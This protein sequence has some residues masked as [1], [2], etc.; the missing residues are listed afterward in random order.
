[1]SQGGRSIA[2][3]LFEYEVFTRD[4]HRPGDSARAWQ[5][6][7]NVSK[8]VSLQ[9]R[10]VQQREGFST[11]A[12][13]FSVDVSP[14]RRNRRPDQVARRR[15]RARRAPVLAVERDGPGLVRVRRRRIRVGLQ[16]SGSRPH[17]R[18][19]HSAGIEELRPAD[20]Q[21]GRRERPRVSCRCDQRER[22]SIRPLIRRDGRRRHVVSHDADREGSPEPA[23]VI[24]RRAA[25]FVARA[26]G[27]VVQVRAAVGECRLQV[28]LRPPVFTAIRCS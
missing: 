8:S 15:H 24:E 28:L 25:R 6:L 23:A 4:G 11:N 7:Y 21:R 19:H 26:L 14:V 16:G 2:G 3:G 5:G 10:Y 1:M 9:G 27:L 18:R 17:R 13:A 22:H 12:M 20:V